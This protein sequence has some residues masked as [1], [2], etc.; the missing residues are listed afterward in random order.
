MTLLHRLPS[1]SLARFGLLP[2][3]AWPVANAAVHSWTNGSFTP[4]VAAPNPIPSVDNLNASGAGTKIIDGVS[5]ENQGRNE[6][7]HESISLGMPWSWSP[8]GS[9]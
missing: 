8:R 5:V 4:G 3:A 2:V 1:A 9:N 7:T 6:R